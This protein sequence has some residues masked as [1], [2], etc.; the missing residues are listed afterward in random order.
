MRRIAMA[1]TTRKAYRPEQTDE[2][3]EKKMQERPPVKDREKI[4]KE[5]QS[6]F[7]AAQ[8]PQRSKDDIFEIT[9]R[10]DKS[11]KK[12]K[13][14]FFR[15]YLANLEAEQ[16][17]SF[18]GGKKET[19]TFLIDVPQGPIAKRIKKGTD[20]EFKFGNVRTRIVNFIARVDGIVTRQMKGETEEVS[21]KAYQFKLP[22]KMDVRILRKSY[23]LDI[24][25]E[26]GNHP[27]YRGKQIKASALIK[28]KANLGSTIVIN[29][30]ANPTQKNE[31][32][33]VD[34]SVDAVKICS[35]RKLKEDEVNDLV[36]YLP[37]EREDIFIKSG[38][39]IYTDIPGRI[40]GTQ[41]IYSIVLFDAGKNHR[42][43]ERIQSYVNDI[44]RRDD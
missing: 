2:E 3:L 27:R 15:A 13:K 28:S 4:K 16:E 17:K 44:T 39:T 9:I 1:K 24:D 35:D 36:I 40:G 7:K 20:L 37:G 32:N 5:F 10:T 42:S 41:G 6:L 25:R 29:D 30:R 8:S 31:F 18:L 11:D 38:K 34:I 43:Y 21:Y 26:V 33:I 19:I 23:I 14:E 22:A 12:G